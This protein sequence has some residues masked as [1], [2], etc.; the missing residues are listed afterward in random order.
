M[1]EPAGKGRFHWSPEDPLCPLCGRGLGLAPLPQKPCDTLGEL[2]R[3]FEM[4]C[5]ATDRLM[6][7]SAPSPRS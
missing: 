3:H 7:A 4:D 2:T 5:P 1:V 6:S